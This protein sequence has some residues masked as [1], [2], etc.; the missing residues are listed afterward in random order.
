MKKQGS[1][2][3]RVMPYLLG[4]VLFFIGAA[5]LLVREDVTGAV[6]FSIA[7]LFAVFMVVL[8][9]FRRDVNAE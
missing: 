7:G 5:R 9:A 1:K 8:N 3:F 4:A 2:P 6:I